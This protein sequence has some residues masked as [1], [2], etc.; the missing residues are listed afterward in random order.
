M[1][2]SVSLGSRHRRRRLLLASSAVVTAVAVLSYH[3]Y[4]YT[5]RRRAQLHRTVALQQ[6]RD[7]SAFASCFYS[8][9]QQHCGGPLNTACLH[10]TQ[11]LQ[12]GEVVLFCA[13]GWAAVP[14]S[15]IPLPMYAASR[16]RPAVSAGAVLARSLSGQEPRL[17]HG[18]RLLPRSAAATA[19][20]GQRERPGR[21]LP[22]DASLAAR[23][24]ALAVHRQL[25]LGGLVASSVPLL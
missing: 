24:L 17:Q 19:S 20:A 11:R 16:F 18:I 8:L 12:N 6:A 4:S 21:C 9:I 13:G 14:P 15:T 5:L 23:T 1:S 2:T 3:Y 7:V 25:L 10:D 22:G